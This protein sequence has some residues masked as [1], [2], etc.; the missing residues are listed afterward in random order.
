MTKYLPATVTS[1]WS[2]GVYTIKSTTTNLYVYTPITTNS[3]STATGYADIIAGTLPLAYTTGNV[4]A[5]PPNQVLCNTTTCYVVA[6]VNIPG[7]NLNNATAVNFAGV[8][9]NGGCL[10]V[11]T[12]P[13]DANGNTMIPEAVVVPV[14]VSGVNDVGSTNVY[15]ISSFTAYVVGNAKPPTTTSPPM[16][17][18]GGSLNVSANCAAHLIA[19]SAAKAYWRVCLQVITEKGNVRTTRN[20]VWGNDVIIAG[21]TRCSVKNETTTSGF[22][23]FGN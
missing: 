4:A 20:D 2:A 15:P 14:S 13:V 16:C 18:G 3:T 19:G 22:T 9:S 5:T 10:P 8:V 6:S 23:V 7:Q 1:P 11:P 17:T 12:C 21:F